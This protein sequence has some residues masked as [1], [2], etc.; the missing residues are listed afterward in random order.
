MYISIMLKTRILLFAVCA[1]LVWLIFQLPKV[2]V[3][4]EGRLATAN[5]QDSIAANLEAHVATP[6]EVREAITAVKKS[7]VETSEKEKNAIFADS[8]AT[9][10]RL[11]SQYDSA[12][13]FAEEASRVLNTPESWRK[14]GDNYYQ[15]YTL[16]LNP[17]RQ[18]AFAAKAQ[19]FYGKVLGAEP[20]NLDV[21]TN[22]AMTYISSANPMQG[23]S[24]LQEVLKRN[25]EHE[26][27]L[28]SMGMLSIQS[29]QFS[30]AVE[31]LTHLVEIN[32]NHV[33]GQLLLG[34]AWME[35]GEKEKARAQFEKVKQMDNDPAVHATVDSYLDD[36]E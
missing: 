5:V 6:A 22:L 20:D 30:R 28:F 29:R 34:I 32:P 7:L 8:L 15:A 19:E 18:G 17:E 3:D 36:L 23:I 26:G 11:A 12:A 13:W 21:K 1:I 10:Y 31:R 33:Q 27:A 16:A 4:N 25:P 9:L 35:S 2:V 14:A 24:M